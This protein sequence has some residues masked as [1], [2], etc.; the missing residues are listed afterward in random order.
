MDNTLINIKDFIWAQQFRF[1]PFQR[2]HPNTEK[3]DIY[4]IHYEG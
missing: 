3:G 4:I 1:L 2:F